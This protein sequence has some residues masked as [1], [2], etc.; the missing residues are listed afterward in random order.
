M[1]S[2]SAYLVVACVTA[3]VALSACQD[4]DGDFVAE[5]T[6]GGD[7][8]DGEE[9]V[10]P[11]V[12]CMNLQAAQDRIQ[13]NGVFFSKSVDATGEGRR[14]VWDRNWIVV[15][16]TPAP[17]ASIGEGEAVLA[18]VKEEEPSAC[19]GHGPDVAA[20]AAEPAAVIT[21]SPATTTQPPTTSTLAPTATLTVA[22][23]TTPP[24]T[25]TTVAP[26][27]NPPPTTTLAPITAAP[28]TRSP[29]TLA[30]LPQTPDSD[31]D[32]SYPDVCIPPAPPD[33]D[34]GDI[35]HRRFTVRG[36][37][38]HGFDG[39]DNDGVGCESD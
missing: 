8:Q 26:T 20:Q 34:C 5:E 28:T 37:D 14:Q 10:M 21:T 11:D 1:K 2:K 18:V 31:C 23:T 29:A 35:P 25:T 4:T 24:T 32:P 30:F 36:A 19:D 22:A 13:E 39:N 7:G 3:V 15:D 6:N 17:G 16:Q 12:V 9:G 27:T 33:L 38:P